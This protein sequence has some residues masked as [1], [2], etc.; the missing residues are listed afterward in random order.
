M[1]ILKVLFVCFAILYLIWRQL[2]RYTHLDYGHRWLNRLMGLNQVLSR[3]YHRLGDFWLDIPEDQGAII[4]ANHQSGMDPAV[5]LAAS[6]RK[7]RF[8][9]TSDYYDMPFAGYI[10]KCADCIPVYRNKDNTIALQKAIEALKNGELVGIFPFGGIHV[11]SEPEPRIRSGVAVL[12]R[13]A[14]VK[15]YPVYIS[16][17]AKFSYNK[18]FTSM[19]FLR[20]HLKL[21]QYSA[22]EN[23]NSSDDVNNTHDNFVLE[24]LYQL[25][26]NHITRS[27][28]LEQETILT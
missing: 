13:Q 26:S 14:N 23:K 25:L 10:L 21:T 19:F 7:I 2:E 8:L 5:L 15:I 18:V 9:T 16:G 1:I 3:R 6:K 24:Q 22:I 11:P 20:S 12:A 27:D 28:D 17:V 4:A